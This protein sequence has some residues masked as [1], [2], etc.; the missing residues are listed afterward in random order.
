MRSFLFLNAISFLTPLSASKIQT[1]GSGDVFLVSGGL[2]SSQIIHQPPPAHR[3]A[4]VFSVKNM[5]GR[6]SSRRS[7]RR[8]SSASNIS[9]TEKGIATVHPADESLDAVSL[10][11]KHLKILLAQNSSGFEDRLDF[12]NMSDENT[13][14]RAMT[15]PGSWFLPF[16]S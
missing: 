11:L 6:A 13:E 10:N 7:S 14:T 1:A 4:P 2:T 3:V 15:R 9:S 8:A 16:I 5:S 12:I